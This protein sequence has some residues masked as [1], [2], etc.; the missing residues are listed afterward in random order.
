V[1]DKAS[2]FKRTGYVAVFDA[3][4]RVIKSQV[5]DDLLKELQESMSP[6]FLKSKPASS[7]ASGSLNESSSQ[8]PVRDMIDPMM[9]PL[10]YR[11]TRVL[12]DDG[13]VDLERPKSWR[14]SNSQITPISEKPAH[15]WDEMHHKERKARD[16]LD[17]QYVG[18]R[19][20]NAF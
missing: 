4:S 10:I 16:F 7:T 11:R 14:P 13:K 9:Y 6:L 5:H 17:S 2:D 3:D 18:K 20:S 19:W 15:S 12:T 1:R 8:S